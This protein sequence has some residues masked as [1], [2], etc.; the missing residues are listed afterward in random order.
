MNTYPIISLNVHKPKARVSYGD[1]DHWMWRLYLDD[2][3]EFCDSLGLP[4]CPY[5]EL[6]QDDPLPKPTPLLYG[7]SPTVLEKPGYWPKRYYIQ[8]NNIMLPVD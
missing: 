2:F 7:I 6:S 5:S 4:V 8:N 3:G 1:V